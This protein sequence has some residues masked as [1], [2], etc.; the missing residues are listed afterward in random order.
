MLH[1]MVYADLMTNPL[2]VPVKV[3]KVETKSLGE[4]VQAC[5]FHPKQ[6]WILLAGSDGEVLLY[7]N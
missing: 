2:V 5:C 7:C 3:L 4:G 6:P 1:G